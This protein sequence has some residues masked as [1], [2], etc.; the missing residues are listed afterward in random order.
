MLQVLE[1]LT[2]TR[3]HRYTPAPLHARTVTPP[4]PLHAR[5]LATATTK[6]STDFLIREDD[7]SKPPH[8]TSD[9]IGVETAARPQAV[10]SS[11]G[12]APA[13]SSAAPVSGYQSCFAVACEAA[14]KNLGR[15]SN[16]ELV[17]TALAMVRPPRPT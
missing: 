2:V 7:P 5:L 10:V 8:N 14:C 12:T 15:R 3:P 6:A 13:P 17:G 9:P 4:A 16:P 1:R 11:G